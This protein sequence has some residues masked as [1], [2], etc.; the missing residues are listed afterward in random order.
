VF[1]IK[2]H[3]TCGGS[4]FNVQEKS[5]RLGDTSTFREFS[6]RRNE[7]GALPLGALSAAPGVSQSRRPAECGS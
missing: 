1:V 2:P 6:K 4:K 5:N 3:K 7:T